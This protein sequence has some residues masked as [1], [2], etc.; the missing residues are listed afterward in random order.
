MRYV[1]RTKP[2]STKILSERANRTRLLRGSWVDPFPFVHGT[3]PEKMVYAEL[4]RRKIPFYFLNDLRFQIPEIEF[5]KS[6]QADFMLPELNVIIEVQ[7]SYWH[8]MEKAIESDALKFAIYELRGFRVLAWWDY[9]ILSRLQQLFAE[10]P[11]LSLYAGRS[12]SAPSELAPVVRTKVDT[13]KGIRT[14]N[15]RRAQSKL[16]KKEPIRQRYKK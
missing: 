7:G 13:S 6:F 12:L 1:K 14:L 5:D 3:L 10:D 4:S 15:K 9:D 16:Y 11:Q 2:L 8:A